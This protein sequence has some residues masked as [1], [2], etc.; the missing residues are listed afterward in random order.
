MRVVAA[1]REGICALKK[2]SVLR[3]SVTWLSSFSIESQIE[4]RSYGIHAS[5]HTNVF[6][7]THVSDLVDLFLKRESENSRTGTTRMTASSIDPLIG[8]NQL[9][10]EHWSIVADTRAKEC[11]RKPTNKWQPLHVAFERHARR[12]LV[13]KKDKNISCVS[14]FQLAV[15]SSL[16]AKQTST[17][18]V[19]N[20]WG[21][22][23]LRK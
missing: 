22:V 3:F 14:I 1:K 7:S 13:P 20:L 23:S 11:S 4:W 6:G 19:S 15:R 12:R 10:K 18:L 9:D 16:R 21:F 2:R 5:S 17:S 8:P